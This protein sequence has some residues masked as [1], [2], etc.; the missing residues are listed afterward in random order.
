[1]DA[2]TFGEQRSNEGRADEARPS[3]YDVAIHA[4]GKTAD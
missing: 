2:S 1:V 4:I 3:G